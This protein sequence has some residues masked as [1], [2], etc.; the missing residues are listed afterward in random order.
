MTTTITGSTTAVQGAMARVDSQPVSLGRAVKSEW[1]KW[2]S[3]RS[4]WAVLGAAVVGM[5]AVGLVI[6]FNTRHLTGNQDAN[7]LASSA[8][9]QGFFLGQ[10]L[11]GALG[12]LFVSSEFSTGM[13]R[14]TFAAV[15]R[16]QPVL[17]AKLAVFFV[18]T[19]VVMTI[20]TVVTFL[21]SQAVIS[22]SR[23]GFSLSDPGVW[24]YVLGTSLYMVLAGVIGGMIAWMV[25]STPGSLVSFFALIFVVP[26][27]FSLFG[28]T[29]KHIAQLFPSQ[30]GEAFTV[31]QPEAPHLSPGA[32]VLVLCAW[33]VAAIVAASIT[34]RRRDA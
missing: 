9:L 7:D 6:G 33:A 27:L 28:S 1:I 21:V 29:G 4:T 5:L 32:G 34:L 24:R 15:P 13:I 3:L 17:W 25:R 12:V 14:S 20:A 19:A 16:R 31:A 30:A 26:Q 18:I 11:I 23:P 8:P 10:L 2:R 22:Q